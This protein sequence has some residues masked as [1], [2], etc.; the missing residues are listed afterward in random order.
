MTQKD[1]SRI[2]EAIRGGV[3]TIMSLPTIR[4]ACINVGNVVGMRTLMLNQFVGS[5]S[6][7]LEADSSAFEKSHFRNEVLRD[8]NAP[9]A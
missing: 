1:Y 4:H 7:M 2:A 9:P 5:F 3:D 6:G 8:G